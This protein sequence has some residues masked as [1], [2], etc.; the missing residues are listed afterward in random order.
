MLLETSGSNSIHDEEKLSTFLESTMQKGD[1][2]DGTVTNEPS[3]MA[4]TILSSLT[5]LT[6]QIIINTCKIFTTENLGLARENWQCHSH[7]WILFQVW[8]VVAANAFLSDCAGDTRTSW[9]SCYSRL[10]LWS[11]RWLEFALE[12]FVRRV[13]ARTASSIGTVCLWIHIETTRKC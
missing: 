8:F 7:R 4:V 9:W 5:T 10:W 12:C 11:C 3:K 6:G 13:L 2:L 1:V